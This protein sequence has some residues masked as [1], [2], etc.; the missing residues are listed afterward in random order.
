MYMNLGRQELGETDISNA[1]IELFSDVYA[2]F[3]QTWGPGIG[4]DIFYGSSGWP[5]CDQEH[6]VRGRRGVFLGR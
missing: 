5:L 4:R 3:S 1:L 6:C 2:G